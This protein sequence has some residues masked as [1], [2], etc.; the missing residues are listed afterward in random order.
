MRGCGRRE[1]RN[2]QG[3]RGG[4]TESV[5]WIE[6]YERLAERALELPFTRLTNN[7]QSDAV[8]LK[9]RRRTART[10]KITPPF[11]APTSLSPRAVGILQ[12]AP[13]DSKYIPPRSERSDGGASDTLSI[14]FTVTLCCR[15]F[16]TAL[17]R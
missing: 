17:L 14:F 16:N 4:I 12:V 15:S 8:V 13:I 6:D 7:R 5:R 3:E 9:S 10:Q 11:G 2:A 1:P